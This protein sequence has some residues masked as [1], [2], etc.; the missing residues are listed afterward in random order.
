M[1]V[2]SGQPPV[3]DKQHAYFS[4][5]SLSVAVSGVFYSA[6]LT[7]FNHKIKYVIIRRKIDLYSV[8]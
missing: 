5:A 6:V 7:A 2:L 8:N 1:V 3:N 4:G